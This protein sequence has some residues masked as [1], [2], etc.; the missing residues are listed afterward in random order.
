MKPESRF[1]RLTAL[2]AKHPEGLTTGAVADH[3]GLLRGAASSILSRAH[4]YGYLTIA[5]ID[6]D[7][8]GGNRHYIW[9]PRA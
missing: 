6:T 3:L 2:M 5:K 1:D 7:E 8:R 4:S 9:R